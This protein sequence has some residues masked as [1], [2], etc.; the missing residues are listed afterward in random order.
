MIL[1]NVLIYCSRNISYF[2]LSILLLN[3]CVFFRIL[4]CVLSE[5]LLGWIYTASMNDILGW[6]V[7]YTVRKVLWTFF[8]TYISIIHE[9][10]VKNTMWASG[11]GQCYYNMSIHVETLILQEGK[12]IRILLRAG[13]HWYIFENL[14]P[15][16]VKHLVPSTVKACQ[17]KIG[18][19][20]NHVLIRFSFIFITKLDFDLFFSYY[21]VH[22]LPLLQNSWEKR[23]DMMT[24]A[25]LCS[26]M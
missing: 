12:N 11:L 23:S 19:L 20:L 6:Y 24:L 3:I 5:Y 13:Q 10:F 9:I 17:C 7:L 26:S 4:W 18:Q 2:F 15:S 1:Q 16:T 22:N 25:V 21:R 14:A 8:H